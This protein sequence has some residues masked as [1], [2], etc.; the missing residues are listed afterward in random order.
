MTDFA[1]LPCGLVCPD[2][3]IA[4]ISD[5]ICRELSDGAAQLMPALGAAH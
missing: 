2:G 1:I 4:R 3:R 5:P